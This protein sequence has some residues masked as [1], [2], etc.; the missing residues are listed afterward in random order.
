ML[1]NG[2]TLKKESSLHIKFKQ[3]KQEQIMYSSGMKL[4]GKTASLC[5]LTKK[6]ILFFKVTYFLYCRCI[7]LTV[8]SGNISSCHIVEQMKQM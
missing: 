7:C 6:Q 5:D 3:K 4:C 2:Q 8:L 1:N